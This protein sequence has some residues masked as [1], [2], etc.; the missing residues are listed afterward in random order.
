MGV[1]FASEM[2]IDWIKHFFITRLNRLSTSLYGEFEGRLFKDFLRRYTQRSV[3]AN[4]QSSLEDSGEEGAEVKKA[5][6]FYNSSLLDRMLDPETSM[7]MQ[8]NL[9][10]IPQ[11]C[12]ILRNLFEYFSKHSNQPS[13]TFKMAGLVICGLILRYTIKYV[14]L[15]RCIET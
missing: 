14:L 10:V 8:S 6:K 1:V 13:V 11:I 5:Y 2:L 12:L 4:E 9:L 3:S 7:A 15:S